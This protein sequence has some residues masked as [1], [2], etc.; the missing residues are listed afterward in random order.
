M[1]G[2]RI[3]A[4][5]RPPATVRDLEIALLE[6]WNSIPQS[7]IDN[8]IASMA[9]RFSPNE[10]TPT[11]AFEAK[12]GLIHKENSPPLASGH[13]D[14]PTANVSTYGLEYSLVPYVQFF[15]NNKIDGCHLLNLTADDL[16]DLHIFKIGHQLLILEAVE[17]L[18][19]LMM[20]IAD[21]D[22]CA[23]DPNYC[24]RFID[25]NCCDA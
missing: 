4:R 12:P 14:M 10:N 6:E 2:R 16:E 22:C 18:R 9:N 17:L 5:P 24:A 20:L 15:L 3:A 8:L 19:Q 1:L 23:T 11:V 7:L 25:A 21:T 13:N